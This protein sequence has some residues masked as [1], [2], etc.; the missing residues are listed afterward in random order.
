VSRLCVALQILQNKCLDLILNVPRLYVTSE[1][2]ER[3]KCKLISE[4]SKSHHEKFY[5]RLAFADNSLID[6]I[7]Q[8]FSCDL[9]VCVFCFLF[10]LLLY[11]Y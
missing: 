11:F 8:N 6:E 7:L 10:C 2:H 5:R 1:T 3:T 4:N 9:M